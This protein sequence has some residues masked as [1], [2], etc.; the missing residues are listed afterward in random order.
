MR[1]AANL[2]NEAYN[3]YAAVTKTLRERSRWRFYEAIKLIVEG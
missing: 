3:E 1:G 2:R